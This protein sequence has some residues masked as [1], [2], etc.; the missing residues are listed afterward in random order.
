MGSHFSV[1][2]AISDHGHV[3][4]VDVAGRYASVKL[5]P[6]LVLTIS[7]MFMIAS[8]GHIDDTESS[9]IQ[10]VI[11]RNEAL[12]QFA[13]TYVRH[14]PLPMFLSLAPQGLSQRDKTCILSNV[15]D[16]MLADGLLQRIEQQTFDLLLAAFGVSKKEFAF[17]QDTL[18]FK[19]DKKVLGNFSLAMFQTSMTPHLALAAAVLYIMS[20][21]GSIDQHEIGRL[22]MLVAEFDGL[23]KLAVAYVKQ[24]KRER[25]IQE[26][27]YALNEA[28]KSFILL[29]VYDTMSADGVIAVTEDK[30]F[31]ALLSKFGMAE[32]ALTKRLQV[33]EDKN[34]KPF[35]MGKAD[36]AH[37]FDVAFLDEKLTPSLH[38]DLTS[39]TLG[40]ELKRTM[41]SN[42]AQVNNDMGDRKSVV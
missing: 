16:A 42:V 19:N 36:V 35:D 29:N 14:V 27:A 9:Q 32:S 3:E 18:A 37:V 25:F 31:Q 1:S 13:S 4:P 22:E 39:S 10:S 11:G 15:C 33:L 23:Q 20:A 28:Q 40:L 30:I 38:D 7:L 12:V 2:A 34:I 26:V 21:D 6:P 5:T 17:Y 24:N 41:Q 8:D